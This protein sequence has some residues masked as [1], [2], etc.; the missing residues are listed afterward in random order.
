MKVKWNSNKSSISYQLHC[1]YRQALELSIEKDEIPPVLIPSTAILKSFSILRRKCCN[2]I[3]ILY[4]LCTLIQLIHCHLVS[5]KS[6][7]ALQNRNSFASNAHDFI[8]TVLP[9]VVKHTENKNSTFAFFFCLWRKFV[10]SFHLS[11]FHPLCQLLFTILQNP[12]CS[13]MTRERHQIS[14]T[15]QEA[16]ERNSTTIFS[17]SSQRE[18]VNKLCW[19]Y[20]T[21][22]KKRP[23]PLPFKGKLLITVHFCEQQRTGK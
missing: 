9:S 2:T 4:V 10:I 19:L 13:M 12:G 7:P 6:L 16:R 17:L 1:R 8:N 20:S 15:E 18:Q 21:D 11:S 14:M 22:T 23:R 3:N 5:V